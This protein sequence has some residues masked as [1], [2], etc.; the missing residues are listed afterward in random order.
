[1]EVFIVLQASFLATVTLSPQEQWPILAK[2][3]KRMS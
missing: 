3:E 1:V 2:K